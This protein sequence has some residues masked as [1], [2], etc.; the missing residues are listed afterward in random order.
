M[1]RHLVRQRRAARTGVAGQPSTLKI[2]AGVFAVALS[3][4]ALIVAPT[5]TARAATTVTHIVGPGDIIGDRFASGCG[6]GIQVTTHFGAAA[7]SGGHR[8]VYIS[9]VDIT[10][11]TGLNPLLIRGDIAN[12]D[13][14]RPGHRASGEI[15]LYS[16]QTHR[17]QIATPFWGREFHSQYIWIAP[18]CAT[19]SAYQIW[20]L[21]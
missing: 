4:V 3:M 21:R 12:A 1:T 5:G 14:G 8:G 15:K 10:N 16:G 19:D 9:Y 11:Y 2:V 6:Q 17:W 7:T 20:H 13:Y 18:F